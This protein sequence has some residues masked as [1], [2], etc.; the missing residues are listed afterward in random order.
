MSLPTPTTSSG[1]AP[2]LDPKQLA[3]LDGPLIALTQQCGG[4]LR[5]VMFAYFSF[6]SRRTDFYL[7]PHPDDVASGT[8]KMGF[9][10]GDAEK[11]LLAAFR[12]FPLRRIP[13]G[14]PPS[15]Q[16]Q[17]HQR[18]ATP[19]T[20]NVT[21]SQPTAST[22]KESSSPAATAES[23]ARKEET[24]SSKNEGAKTASSQKDTRRGDNN[25]EQS[26]NMIGVTYN[27]EGKQIPVGNG[28]STPRYKWT[29]TIDECSVLVGVPKNLRGKDLDVKIT[30]TT[31]SVK[32]KKPL[33]ETESA[34]ATTFVEGNLTQKVRVDESTWSLEGGVVIVTLDKVIKTFWKTILV[35]DEEIDTDLVDSRRHI[36]EYDSATQG[37]IRKCIF[38]QTQYH[39]G[40]LSSDEILGKAEAKIPPLPAGVEYIDKKK[41][42]DEDKKAIKA[43]EEAE[44]AAK[45]GSTS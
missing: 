22:K 4:D 5:K 28:G 21:T 36:S 19:T 12:Q 2:G 20:S 30:A 24:K 9:Q 13:K 6:L 1:P 41:L 44:A 40:G 42:D 7:V 43:K 29:Q 39:K 23:T 15:Q 26:G 3:A 45:K 31:L 27:E 10:E 11:L 17:Q 8:S 34:Q 35:G 18:A 32:S 33:S 16:P 38:D 25:E 14:G 37:Q